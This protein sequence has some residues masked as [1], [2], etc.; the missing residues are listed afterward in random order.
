MKVYIVDSEPC[1]CNVIKICI[2]N[3]RPEYEIK[4]FTNSDDV[5]EFYKVDRP[6]LCIFEHRLK[7]T[8][9]LLLAKQV[10]N[11]NSPYV[12]IITNAFDQ[13]ELYEAREKNIINSV[14]DKPFIEHIQDIILKM[15]YE[16]EPL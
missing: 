16:I 9:G 10:K 11:I 12:A 5:L 3:A 15:I 1:V 7:P 6:G 4:T 13:D 2:E 8:N 14:V